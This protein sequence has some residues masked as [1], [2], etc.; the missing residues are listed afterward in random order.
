MFLARIFLLTVVT[1]TALVASIPMHRAR[2]HLPAPFAGDARMAARRTLQLRD[3]SIRDLLADLNLATGVRFFAHSTVADDRVTLLAHSRPLAETLAA[4]SSFFGFE[5]KREGNAPDFGY[6]LY[7]PAAAVEKAQRGQ[8]A[9]LIE[10]VELIADE[11][12]LY[13]RL[14]GLPLERIVERSDTAMRELSANTDPERRRDLQLEVIVCEQLK[15]S[16]DWRR[17]ANR[18]F[19]TLKRE[20]LTA[21]L[22]G[23]QE[24]FTWP[25]RVA[26]A[27]ELPADVVDELKAASAAGGSS[28][29][30]YVGPIS[31][32]RLRV[33]GD[34]SE[35][36]TI[37]WHFTI[38]KRGSGNFGN[39]EFSSALPSNSSLPDGPATYLHEPA[40]W[41]AD[42]LLARSVSFAIV[43]PPGMMSQRP[44]LGQALLEMAKTTRVDAIA[45]AFHTTRIAGIKVDEKSLG[46]ALSSLAR[47]TGHRWWKQDDFIMLRSLAFEADRRKEP[48][49][50][51]VSRWIQRCQ[52]GSLEVDDYGEI[53]ALTDAQLATLSRLAVRGEFPDSL[54]PITQ[55]K[56][57]LRLWNSL[58]QSQRRRA[59]GVGLP[60]ETLGPPQQKLYSAAIRDP[61]AS[62]SNRGRGLNDSSAVTEPIVRSRLRLETRENKMWALKKGDRFSLA[63]SG[64]KEEALQQLQQSDPG[65]KLSDLRG[66]VF[67]NVC[68]TYESDGGP[69]TRAWATLPHRW[70]D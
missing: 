61:R 47:M 10:T 27:K 5:W 40:G 2:T 23:A 20:Q 7:Q 26:G 48:P 18:F 42:P 53:A 62:N 4:V 17:L 67:T 54:Q 24:E 29:I 3:Q 1:V 65:V 68:F 45:D 60:Y 39:S 25:N 13:D 6:T 66:V 37:K 33:T 36:P 52:S 59:R 21:F 32:A 55:A 51:A 11:V 46:E 38:G 31:Y 35:D 16:N 12:A 30:P 58:T 69:S 9:R 44:T 15:A 56:D 34:S 41:L 22:E 49:A 14:E 57:H 43:S 63:G 19:R 28:S 64:T 50:T 70:E 8:R